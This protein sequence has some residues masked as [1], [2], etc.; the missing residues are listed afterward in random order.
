MRTKAFR[1]KWAVLAFLLLVFFLT[2]YYVDIIITQNSGIHFFQGLLTGTFYET[3]YFESVFY[4]PIHILFGIWCLPV[5]LLELAGVHA[6]GTVG[7]YLWAKLLVVGFCIGVLWLYREMLKLIGCRDVD[8][9]LFFLCASPLFWGPTMVLAQYDVIELFFG[10]WAMLLAAREKE[11][12]WKTLLLLSVAVACKLLFTFGAILLLLVK[13]KRL[14]YLLRDLIVMLALTAVF[15][16][17][18]RVG[19]VIKVYDEL[20]VGYTQEKIIS[21]ALPGLVEMPYLFLVFFADCAIAY[22]HMKPADSREFLLDMA[23]LLTSC[24]SAFVLLLWG[25]HPFWAVLLVPFLALLLASRE[26]GQV[27]NMLLGIVF[28][29]GTMALQ[30]FV[31]FWMYLEE[32]C[33][34]YL[35]LRNRKSMKLFGKDILS[36]SAIIKALGLQQMM[37]PLAALTLVIAAVLLF[38]NNIWRPIRGTDA[39]AEAAEKA[40]RW[41]ELFLLVFMVLYFLASCV[42]ALIM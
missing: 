30:V 2:F 25:S 12:S 28:Q 37:P 41:M 39:G 4:I 22:F 9:W 20:S 27:E 6:A 15:F 7:A 35:I 17:I 16:L 14:G 18:F 21:T 42:I 36:G 38:R 1:G 13:E 29:L 8:F 33:F 10:M 3:Y 40:K 31:F 11:L 23:W 5:T 19:N 34:S 26:N 32:S 24:Y